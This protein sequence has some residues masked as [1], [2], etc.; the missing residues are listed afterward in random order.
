MLP[1]PKDLFYNKNMI[2]AA[3]DYW[4]LPREHNVPLYTGNPVF[5]YIKN[6]IYV[7]LF[8]VFYI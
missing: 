7:K 6:L 2:N 3:H 8:F 5:I 1:S 4:A